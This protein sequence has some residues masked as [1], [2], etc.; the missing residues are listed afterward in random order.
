MVG[1]AIT[2]REAMQKRSLK[3]ATK[4]L[5]KMKQYKVKI[6]NFCYRKAG[7]ALTKWG[8]IEKSP[9]LEKGLFS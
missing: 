4:L 2:M 7:R 5:Q 9:I 6:D 1:S 3:K 8:A